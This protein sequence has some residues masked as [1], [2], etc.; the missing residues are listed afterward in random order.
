MKI[1]VGTRNPAKFD[2]YSTI[3][4]HL[5]TAEV[6]SLNDIQLD[7][8]VEENGVT[9]EENARK[10]AR[11]YADAAHMPTLSVDEALYFPGLPEE[12]QPGVYVRRHMGKEATDEEMLTLYIEKIKQLPPLQRKAIWVYAICLAQPYAEE[13][14]DQ[15]EIKAVFIETPRLPLLP[16]YP[17]SSILVDPS[18]GKSLRDLT[19]EEEKQRLQPVYEQVERIVKTA[20]L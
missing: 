13:I 20:L 15:V 10:K 6:C 18:S 17:L 11:A 19:P 12:E 5:S 2:R 9:A 16:G 8:V 1:L 14:C 7:L 4:R 3:L